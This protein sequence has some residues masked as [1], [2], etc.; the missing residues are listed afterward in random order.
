MRGKRKKPLDIS[1]FLRRIPGLDQVTLKVT[2][3]QKTSL[4]ELVRKGLIVMYLKDIEAFGNPPKEHGFW[5][6]DKL[7]VDART[8]QQLT[9]TG[10]VIGRA[11]KN[12]IPT[13]L[14]LATKGAEAARKAIGV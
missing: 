3:H 9:I 12:G 6:R 8:S 7:N 10:L 13:E 2:K 1:S 4:D 11:V 14:Q 5:G